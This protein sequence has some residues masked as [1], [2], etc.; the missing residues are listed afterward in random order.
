[1]IFILKELLWVDPSKCE[2]CVES[3]FTKKKKKTSFQISERYSE[4]LD[5]IHSNIDYLKFVQTTFEKKSIKLLYRYL[6]K[7]LLYLFY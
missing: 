1:M 3:K 7:E 4:I 6:H 2:V 5:L